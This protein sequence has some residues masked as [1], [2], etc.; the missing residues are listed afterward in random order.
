MIDGAHLLHER[1]AHLNAC[2]GPALKI[3][4]DPRLHPL[5]AFLRRSSLDELPQ[6]VN[7]LRGEMSLVGPR[8]ALPHEV[9]SYLPHYH[10]RLTVRTGHDRALAGQRPDQRPVPALD[11]DGRLVRA[12]LVADR[13]RL[14]P[15]AHIA[16]GAPARRSLVTAALALLPPVIDQSIQRV[17][18]DPWSAAG[19]AAIVLAAAYLALRGSPWIAAML[20]FAVPFAAYR[21]VAQT[22][23]TLEKCLA[24]GTAIGL[25]LGGAPAWPRSQG[26]RL[27]LIA[28]AG[29][30]FAIAL[31]A[32]AASY[33][34]HTAREFF[35]QAEYLV[36]LWCAATFIERIPRSTLYF[37]AGVA[38]AAAIVSTFAI[39][40]AVIGGAPSGIWVNGHALPRVAGTLEGPNQLAGFI[41]ATLPVLWLWPLLGLAFAPL[42]GY[43]TGASSAAMI[44]TQ[45]RA[46]IVVAAL[47]YAVL[48]RLRGAVA[49]ASAAP[50]AIGAV[51]GVLVSA[52]WLVFSA[53]ASLADIGRLFL[54]DIPGQPGGGVG[55]RA[56]LWPAAIAVFV[57]HPI[58]GAGAGN[59]ELLLP[60][61][62][63]HG[64][65]TQAASLPLQTLAEQGIVGFIALAVFAVVALR[66]TFTLSR[67]P[68]LALAAF[69]AVGALFVH[70]IVDDL[71]FYP[72]VA[73]LCWLLLG[74]G[75]AKTAAA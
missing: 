27:L 65:Q 45:S 44:L 19:Y 55:T 17:P 66:E 43:V 71:F 69:L 67:S 59:F 22:T 24:F 35:K 54:F 63:L 6:L 11:G 18:L 20:A 13:R 72:K 75:T 31:S 5:G 37:A 33:P 2:D 56:Q 73:A 60:S 8:P 61:V 16:G 64:V 51:A 36:L 29:L 42:R 49:R 58:I 26:P 57:R 70:R 3:P 9:K 14:D 34:V 30:L 1:V 39:S 74:A 47:S 23:L 68:P 53:H 28:G 40:Q 50:M 32:L 38:S 41:E 46:G 52:A 21:D 15:C 10:Q 4:N 48:W 25:L 62:G 12:Q 7:V